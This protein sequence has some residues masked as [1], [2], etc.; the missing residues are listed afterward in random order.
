[1]I[2]MTREVVAYIIIALIVAGGASIYLATRRQRKLRK[3]RLRGIKRHG[4]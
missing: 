3:L 2:E 4:H 1:M